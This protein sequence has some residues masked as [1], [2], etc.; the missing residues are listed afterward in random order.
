MQVQGPLLPLNGLARCPEWKKEKREEEEETEPRGRED[1]WFEGQVMGSMGLRGD[2]G[3][4][5]RVP[6]PPPPRSCLNPIVLRSLQSQRGGGDIND[7]GGTER[8]GEDYNATLNCTR[9]R[10]LS[11]ASA[12]A[13][14]E[15]K[16]Q[17]KAYKHVS[18]LI[19]VGEKG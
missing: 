15:M 13:F 1:L 12:V 18:L 10:F 17:S 16:E 8:R 11:T 2:S 9:E 7:G 6:H 5:P 4:T 19:Y 14:L 3:S